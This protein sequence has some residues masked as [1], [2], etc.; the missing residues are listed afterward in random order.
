MENAVGF[1]RRDPVVPVPSAE[2]WEASGAAWIKA[3]DRIASRDHYR[4]D[5]PIGDLF[6]VGLDRMRPLPGVVFDACDWRQ[7][8]AD[9]TGTVMIDSN[10]YGAGPRWHGLRL[11]V[12]VRASGIELRGPDGETITTFERVWGHDPNTRVDPSG[13]LAIIARKP[14]ARGGE[15]DPRRFPRERGGAAR[16]DERQRASRPD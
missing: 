11:N 7:A 8:K 5:V 16:P 10:R 14:R 2:G 13:L 3:C 15:P 12:G 1:V 9:R 4:R 6:A